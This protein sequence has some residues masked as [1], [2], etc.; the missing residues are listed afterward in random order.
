[1]ALFIAT[2]VV[3]C[4]RQDISLVSK[5][6]YQ[7]E[8]VYQD[9]MNRVNNADS[10]EHKPRIT[11]EQDE[12]VVSFNGLSEITKGEVNLFRPSDATLDQY[13]K[14]VAGGNTVQQFKLKNNTPGMY[15]ARMVWEHKGKEYFFEKIIVL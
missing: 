8:L 15:R 4:F 10:L 12:L 9:Q 14:L 6:Y 11:I 2:L 7:D 5:T 3:V 13:F 1:F